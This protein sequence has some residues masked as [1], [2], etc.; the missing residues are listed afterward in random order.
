M[1]AKRKGAF[2]FFSTLF[3]FHFTPHLLFCGARQQT[4]SKQ[5]AIQSLFAVCSKVARQTAHLCHGRINFFLAEDSITSHTVS[6]PGLSPDSN[7]WETGHGSSTTAS[8][9]YRDLAAAAA[10]TVVVIDIVLEL[11]GKGQGLLV[12]CRP[13]EECFGVVCQR[14]WD[15]VHRRAICHVYL[16]IYVRILEFLDCSC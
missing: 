13:M 4:A 11:M 3:H 5:V 15:C 16:V 8:V 2:T 14:A 6:V 10:S 7:G 12:Y 1:N 9:G